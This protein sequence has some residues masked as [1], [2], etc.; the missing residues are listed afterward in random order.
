MSNTFTG[1]LFD[2][3]FRHKP[4]KD[5]F[6]NQWPANLI[7]GLTE[8]SAIDVSTCDY[9]MQSDDEG[10]GRSYS[11]V[12][13]KPDPNNPAIPHKIVFGF[14]C[15]SSLANKQA[16]FDSYNYSVDGEGTFT[17]DCEDPQIVAQ[18]NA[19]NGNYHESIFHVIMWFIKNKLVR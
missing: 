13:N 10:R 12:E 6:G 15:W 4:L 9:K 16:G 7:C 14:E 17:V 1:Q 3:D 19:F 18:W 8:V 5:C 11:V 2:V